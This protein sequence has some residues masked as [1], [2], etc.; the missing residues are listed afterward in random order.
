[1][2]TKTLLLRCRDGSIG[3]LEFEAAQ[4]ND[5]DSVR[6]MGP[7]LH[8]AFDTM[9]TSTWDALTI[10]VPE[11]GKST[12]VDRIAS[13]VRPAAPATSD[14]RC[15]GAP[16]LG[17]FDAVDVEVERDVY[18]IACERFDMR[19]L[20]FEIEAL[21]AFRVVH[22]IETIEDARAR[23]G[24][25]HGTRMAGMLD[26]LAIPPAAA[27]PGPTAATL[28]KLVS[29]AAFRY[30]AVLVLTRPATPKDPLGA[31]LVCD[32][33]RRFH[34]G[35]SNVCHPNMYVGFATGDVGDAVNPSARRF[36]AFRGNVDPKGGAD[37]M[38]YADSLSLSS[39]ELVFD[40]L[41]VSEAWRQVGD[42]GTDAPVLPAEHEGTALAV[43]GFSPNVDVAPGAVVAKSVE[44]PSVLLYARSDLWWPAFV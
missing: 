37:S 31:W 36:V 40:G 20:A 21:V 10:S 42:D 4:L 23:F 26:H 41:C 25:M 43:V 32:V 35:G 7:I 22:G 14:P 30:D 12:A 1:M 11:L 27:V 33:T 17:A 44:E 3:V 19:R 15:P 13:F 16:P 18:H 34:I 8:T 6:R 2:D 38:F 29:A 24:G 39:A 9:A 5:A 28:G